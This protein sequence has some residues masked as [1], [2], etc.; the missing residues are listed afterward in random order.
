M[1]GMTKHPPIK[2]ADG[3]RHD[4]LPA[5]GRDAF[6]PFYDILS[7]AL[8]V[9]KLHRALIDRAELADGQVALEI[10]CGTGT[11]CLRAK[12]AHPGV[13][14][15]GLDPDPLALARARRKT[16]G[17]TGIRFE[18][19]Y[20]QRLPF[21]DAAFD[22]VLSS[23]MLHH[24]DDDGKAASLAEA[25]RVLRPGGSLYVL[26]MTGD[27]HGVHGLMARRMSRSGH[28]A[29]DDDLPRLLAAAGFACDEVATHRHRVMG[30]VAFYR[31]VRPA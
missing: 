22:R 27:L 11:L 16:G 13:R 10:G 18:Q 8:G 30:R 7:S 24:L 20:A 4:Y 2:H 25:L 31:A 29:G 26:D 12:Q 21:D 9:P 23:L 19:G 17:L 5:A 15:V 14:V 6:L 28:R 1:A 3:H